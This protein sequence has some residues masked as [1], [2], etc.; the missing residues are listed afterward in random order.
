VT[1]TL[2]LFVA[3][4]A[5]VFVAGTELTRAADVIGERTG[6]GRLRA[7]VILLATATSLPELA[8]DIAAVRIGAP[9]LAAGDLFGSSM[10]NMLILALLGVLPPRDHVFQRAALDHALAAS[11]GMIMTALAA[12]FVLAPVGLTLLGNG[13]EPLILLVVYVVGTLTIYRQGV[14]RGDSAKADTPAPA[15]DTPPLRAAIIR[16]GLAALAIVVVA[17][18]FARTAERL[19]EVSG[20]GQTF[21]GTLLVGM[22]TS[23]PEVVTSVAAVRLKAFDLAVGNLF[24][25]NAF[26]MLVFLPMELAHEGGPLF[27]ALDSSHALTAF[28]AV[29]LM[30]IG[31]SAIVYRAERRW[32]LVEPGSTLMIISYLAG[33]WV[34]YGHAAR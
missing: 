14:L 18:V 22:S 8:T 13:V 9:D 30:G 29:V 23:L 11:L 15:T 27:A 16:F 21:V 10:A 7:G 19:A 17:P 32:A 12:V 33:L 28:F 3:C 4:T 31:L 2:L 5:V 24:G 25:S 34:L 6:L 26:N 1:V 20:L